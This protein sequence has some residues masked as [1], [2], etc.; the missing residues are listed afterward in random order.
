MKAVGRD[1]QL[2]LIVHI[3][4]QVQIYYRRWKKQETS[5]IWT[6]RVPLLRPM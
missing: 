3:L 2:S 5:M 6:L 1:L 4:L